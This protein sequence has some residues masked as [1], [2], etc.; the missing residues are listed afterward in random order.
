MDH[1]V[2]KQG[3]APERVDG[4]AR[5]VAKSFSALLIRVHLCSS[6]AKLLL[7]LLLRASVSLW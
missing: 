7:L 6:V 5:R 3:D 1:L 4:I 2:V